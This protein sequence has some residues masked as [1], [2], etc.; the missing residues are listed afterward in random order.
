MGR[1]TLYT[2]ELADKI[3]LAVRIGVPL[4]VAGQMNGIAA[5]TFWLWMRKS[6]LGEEPYAGFSEKVRTA[7]AETM[8]L[9]TGTLRGA[10]LSGQWQAAAAYMRMRWPKHFAERTEITGAN[11]GPVSIE[12]SREL[13]GLTDDELDAIGA[14]F[15]EAR[16]GVGDPGADPGG[17]GTP[18]EG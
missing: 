8:G 16:S 14:L 2:P 9:F 1:P 18:E 15:A 11:G 5:S 4:E 6:D 7:E 12:I 13:E 10:A 17:E 3:V